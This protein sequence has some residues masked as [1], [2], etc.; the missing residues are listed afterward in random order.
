[1]T[2]R[3]KDQEYTSSWALRKK[4]RRRLGKSLE[5]QRNYRVKTRVLADV[6]SLTS[7]SINMSSDEQSQHL[8]KPEPMHNHLDDRDCEQPI[9]GRPQASS[10]PQINLRKNKQILQLS[11][12]REGKAEVWTKQSQKGTPDS[13]T[14]HIRYRRTKAAKEKSE[15]G[16]QKQS[17]KQ[18]ENLTSEKRGSGQLSL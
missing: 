2:K 4:S 10:T 18:K 16:Q 12:E 7:S 11:A 13:Q 1:M 9:V 15:N 5:Y 8:N 14:R 6:L 17:E 3:G